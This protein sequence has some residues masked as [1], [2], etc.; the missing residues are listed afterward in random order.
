MIVSLS[1]TASTVLRGGRT[2][3]H[4]P[5]PNALICVLA[6]SVL[7]ELPLQGVGSSRAL[8]NGKNC[9]ANFPGIFLGNL[10]QDFL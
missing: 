9:S 4:L 10:L 6:N 8:G 1:I 7:R 2:E 3:A 5:S